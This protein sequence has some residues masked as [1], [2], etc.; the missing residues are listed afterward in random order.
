MVDRIVSED[1]LNEFVVAQAMMAYPAEVF[2]KYDTLLGVNLSAY[3]KAHEVL[4]KKLHKAANK[5]MRTA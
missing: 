3:R 1:D 5:R 4:L 2:S